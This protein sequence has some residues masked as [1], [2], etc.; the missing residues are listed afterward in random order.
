MTRLLPIFVL[1]V[2]LLVAQSALAY[3][4]CGY[5]ASS[6]AAGADSAMSHQGHTNP[7]DPQPR[8]DGACPLAGHCSMTVIGSVA[9]AGKPNLPTTSYA[10]T[11]LTAALAGGYRAR[12]YRPPS[13]TA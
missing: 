8:C 11:S 7:D 10:P 3:A 5:M 6:V 1:L 4:S 9:L 12:P 13:V 2:P